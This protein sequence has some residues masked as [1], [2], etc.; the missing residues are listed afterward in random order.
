MPDDEHLE[1]QVERFEHLEDPDRLVGGSP[2]A[3][4]ELAQRILAGMT[5]R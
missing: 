4:D 2:L 5:E 1:R 3:V